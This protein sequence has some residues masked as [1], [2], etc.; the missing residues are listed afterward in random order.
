MDSRVLG[1]PYDGLTQSLHTFRNH[2][3][4]PD[5]CVVHAED[6][7]PRGDRLPNPGV[8]ALLGARSDSFPGILGCYQR[9][10]HAWQYMDDKTGAQ[11]DEHEIR[12]YYSF[13]GERVYATLDEIVSAELE[14]LSVRMTWLWLLFVFR[15]DR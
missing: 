6:W 9:K 2:C 7:K 4:S 12:R 3:Q 10:I 5:R 11:L 8:P 14:L 15:R 1:M 13:C